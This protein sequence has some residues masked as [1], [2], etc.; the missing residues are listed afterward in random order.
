MNPLS[1]SNV[2]KQKSHVSVSNKY[3]GSHSDGGSGKGKDAGRESCGDRN[4]E[5]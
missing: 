2:L 4:L 1:E 3:P 5:G